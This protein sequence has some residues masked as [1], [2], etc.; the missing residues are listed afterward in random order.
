M[1]DLQPIALVTGVMLVG[2]AVAMLAPLVTDLAAGDGVWPAFAFG[3]GA[4]GFV[5]GSLA[6]SARG[7]IPHLSM[8]SA[9]LLTTGSW[10]ALTA[11]AAI[12]L[13]LAGANLTIADAFF[14]SMSGLT[15][16]GSTVMTLLDAQPEALLLWRAILQWIGGVGI[17]VTA[18]AILPILQI[19]GMQLFRLES[20]DASDKLFPRATQIATVIAV[21]YVGLTLACAFTYAALGMSGFDAFAHAMTTIATGGFSTSDA[22]MGKFVEF[23]ADIAAIVF[24]LAGAAPFGV[25]MLAMRGEWRAAGRDPQLGPFLILAALLVLVMT[26]HLTL[27]ERYTGDEALR[28]AAFNVVSILTGT[29]FATADYGLW[30][31]FALMMFFII[32]FIGGCAGSTA[33]GIKMFRFQVAF[34]A[35]R[36][37]F[38]SMVRP[39]AVTAL[40]Y[41][42][43]RLSESAI[44]AVLSFFFLFFCSFIVLAAALAGLGC[45]T[46]TA[47][48]A[49]ATAISNVGPGLGEMI[50]PAGN[51]SRMPEAAKWLLSIGML[52][53]RLEVFTVLVLLTPGFWRS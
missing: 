18:I 19:G 41:G 9:F 35:F 8:R 1:R 33:C 20:S 36:A 6:L 25:Y 5:G 32:T 49:S 27:A 40:N 26:T 15:T 10:L 30:P 7:E 16:T 14:E 21:I 51:F 38:G 11:F 45:D 50:G 22:S 13:Y 37:Y 24:M 53:G 17:V 42:G 46:V 52:I 4:S 39:R 31:P 23:N 2:L 34:A 47:L 28:Y 44:Y 43:R 48:S 3:A 29:G 12:P